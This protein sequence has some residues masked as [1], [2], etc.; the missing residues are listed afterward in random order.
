MQDNVFF[1]Q[2]P[3]HKASTWEIHYTVIT[4][5]LPGS[6]ILKSPG[7]QHSPTHLTA[8]IWKDEQNDT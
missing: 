7:L 2:N 6:L 4:S 8:L 1:I 5:Y 3:R